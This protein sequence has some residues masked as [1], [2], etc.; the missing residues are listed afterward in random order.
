VLIATAEA[1]ATATMQL[2]NE[3]EQPEE[4]G[5]PPP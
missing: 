5:S 3:K 1:V 2:I 4:F